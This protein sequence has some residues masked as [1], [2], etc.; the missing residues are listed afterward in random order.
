MAI[1]GLQKASQSPVK[2]VPGWTALALLESRKMTTT[3]DRLTGRVAFASG[4]FH[5]IR[6]CVEELETLTSDVG[7]RSKD[8]EITIM[9]TGIL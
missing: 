2:D 4:S 8:T 1:K 9:E 3:T 5:G 6:S 7:R